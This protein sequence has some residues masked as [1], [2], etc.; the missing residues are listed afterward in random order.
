MPLRPNWF[1][2][3]EPINQRL[4]GAN[5]RPGAGFANGNK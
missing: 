1:A 2:I 4:R 3:Y 5:S